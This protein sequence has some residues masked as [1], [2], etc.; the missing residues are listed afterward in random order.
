MDHFPGHGSIKNSPAVPFQCRKDM[1]YD[2]NNGR[3]SGMT[4]DR[5]TILIIDDYPLNR[6]LLS[7]ILGDEGFRLLEAVD[8]S[9]GLTLATEERPDLIL[10]DILLPD[11]DG[12]AVC[13]SLHSKPATH[14]IPI[15]FISALESVDARIK[16]FALGAV[17]YIPRP[18]H[19]DEVVAR[20]KVHLRLRR[21]YRLILEAQRARLTSIKEA[22]RSLLTDPATVAEAA[23]AV[24]YEFLEEAG[25]DFYEILPFSSTLIGYF[26]ADISGH[27]IGAAMVHSAIKTVLQSWAGSL[28]SPLETMGMMNRLLKPLF[29]PGDYLTAAYVV[30]NRKTAKAS[31]VA[32]GHPPLLQSTAAGRVLRIEANGDPVGVFQN[33]VFGSCELQLTTGDRLWLYTDG[34]VEDFE[35][36]I[37]FASGM[38]RLMNAIAAT[39]GT[40]LPAAIDA[41]F[42]HTN[43]KH[44]ILRDDRLILACEALPKVIDD[45]P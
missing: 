10:L 12:Y 31:L 29:Q 6:I 18:F 24:K 4:G 40:A 37:T 32:C 35:A 1:S 23:A 33:P 8:G 21:A 15:I 36:G 38:Q 11:T 44:G 43:P 30:V 19:R 7:S 27:D 39:T 13:E 42:T 25:G 16:G 3:T 41:I 34:M 17:D 45:V 28:Y 5:E 2:E 20:V 22:H 26:V 14:D 9:S